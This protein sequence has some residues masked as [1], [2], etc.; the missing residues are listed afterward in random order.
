MFT[1]SGLRVHVVQAPGITSASSLV[2]VRVEPYQWFPTAEP[3][4]TSPAKG[5]PAVFDEIL[6]L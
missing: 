5:D 1:K 2:K 3:Q 4:K 6:E